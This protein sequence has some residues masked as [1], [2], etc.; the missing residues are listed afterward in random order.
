MQ[1]FGVGHWCFHVDIDELFV[2]PDCRKTR[3]LRDLLSYCDGR[4]FCAVPA[5]ELDMHPDRVNS[6]PD[7]NSF[8]TSCYFDVDYIAIPSE[9]PPYVMVQGGIRKRLTGLALSMQKSPLVRMAPDVRY[10]ECNHS[11][12][13]LPL[14]DVSGA[15][16]HYKFLGD[17]VHRI[18]EAISRAEHFA[19]AI[20]YRR[21]Q[22]AAS[23]GRW[24][25]LLL[26]NYSRRFDDSD[27]LIRSGLIKSS[28]SWE[29]Y[30]PVTSVRKG[31]RGY[32]LGLN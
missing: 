28:H 11:T 8:A 14:A 17:I 13:H 26:S 23:S 9:L 30:L 3:T 6:R 27:S 10:I 31:S 25:E 22:G 18:D 24:N 1:R 19:G 21:L 5:I 4:G 32:L 12:T 7:G 15:L 2:Y 16:L 20:S 29:A